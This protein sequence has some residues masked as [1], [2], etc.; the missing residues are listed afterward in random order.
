MTAA[1][2]A[3]EN[4]DH[5]PPM[6]RSRRAPWPLWVSALAILAFFALPFL[7][8][9][10]VSF[11]AMDP[12]VFQGTGLS[13]ANYAGLLD[14]MVTGALANTIILALVVASIS[15]VVAVPATALIC[16]M[17]RRG[18]IAWLLAFLTTLALSEVLITF[19]WQVLLSKRAGISNVLVMLGLWEKSESLSPSYGAMVACLVYVVVPFNV[20]ALYPGF[21]R[22]D[23][24]Y[25]EAARTMGA[26][27]LRAFL[28]VAV[29]ILRGPILA[30][31]LTTIVLALG[32]Y[33]T[34]RILAEP[35]DWTIG[36][37]I[38]QVA[39]TGQNMPYAAAI[40]VMVLAITLLLVGATAALG[41]SGRRP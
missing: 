27:P 25:V 19:S 22:L 18:Q 10:R 12:A 40:A 21:S 33:V 13:L 41:R 7:L 32:A 8:L 29:P 34:P 31:F 26:S 11:A 30:A 39:L 16:R 2:A 28:Q 4:V 14:P 6:G 24:S 15:I 36:V 38:N 3:A 1:P 23:P 5:V 17:G 37:I 20:L 9:F 35:Q